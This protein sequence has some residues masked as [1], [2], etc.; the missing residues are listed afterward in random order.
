[1]QS[2]VADNLGRMV[3]QASLRVFQVISTVG[4]ALQKFVNLGL[5]VLHL[6]PLTLELK[7]FMQL[8]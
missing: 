7:R 5:I 6:V 2:V 1:M 8:I 3:L 4:F